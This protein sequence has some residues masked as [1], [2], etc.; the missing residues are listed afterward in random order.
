MRRMER[1]RPSRSNHN[2]LRLVVLQRHPP[3]LVVLVSPSL[4]TSLRQPVGLEHQCRAAGWTAAVVSVIGTLS[5]N[6]QSVQPLYRRRTASSASQDTQPV[7]CTARI[8][9]LE[10]VGS[11]S[12][13]MRHARKVLVVVSAFPRDTTSHTVST[14]RSDTALPVARSLGKCCWP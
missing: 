8:S 4:W 12:N 1:K 7:C 14:R 9:P 10:Q 13:S 5:T 3:R 11:P 6:H 2:T